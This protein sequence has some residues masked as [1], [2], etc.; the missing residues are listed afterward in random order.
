MTN[1]GKSVSRKSDQILQNRHHDLHHRKKLKTF[2]WLNPDFAKN[3]LLHEHFALLCFHT[4]NLNDCLITKQQWIKSKNMLTKNNFLSVKFIF[5]K[6]LNTFM[7]NKFSSFFE[8]SSAF[9]NINSF[10]PKRA[11]FLCLI[12]LHKRMLIMAARI[13]GFKD[14]FKSTINYPNFGSNKGF[15]SGA[16]LFILIKI[17]FLKLVIIL[18]SKFRHNSAL[19]ANSSLFAKE[20]VSDVD[21]FVVCPG[22]FDLLLMKNRKNAV[23]IAVAIGVSEMNA[24]N[25]RCL[26]L[27]FFS[28]DSTFE[29]DPLFIPGSRSR[30]LQKDLFA[31]IRISPNLHPDWKYFS[32]FVF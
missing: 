17:K 24:Y 23:R 16:V 20:F 8:F 19:S 12:N 11:S 18:N 9:C 4:P 25:M 2:R 31:T 21:T 6:T 22:K 26:R 27:N 1:F 7:P 28:M 13:D 14:K 30:C 32:I 5:K 29:I 15:K 3:V 10:K